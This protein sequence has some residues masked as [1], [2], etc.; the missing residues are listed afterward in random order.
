MGVGPRT[1]A[2]LLAYVPREKRAK[3]GETSREIGKVVYAYVG[4]EA[5]EDH[6]ALDRAMDEKSSKTL[7][8][9]IEGEEHPP[10][11]VN[12]PGYAEYASSTRYRLVPGV[13]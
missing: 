13:W 5:I 8:R 11:Q 6:E 12:L 2:W 10:L 9:V 7:E 3:V 4:G 1:Y